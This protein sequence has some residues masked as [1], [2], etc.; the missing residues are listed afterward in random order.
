MQQ[1]VAF[2]LRMQVAVRPLPKA[3]LYRAVAGLRQKSR[4]VEV[5]GVL[6]QHLE[7]DEVGEL[8]ADHGAVDE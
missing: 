5:L 4:P 2:L 7:V 6:G 3:L 1:H 8:V